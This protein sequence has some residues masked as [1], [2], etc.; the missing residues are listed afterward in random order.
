MKNSSMRLGLFTLC[1][2]VYVNMS[3]ASTHNK[4]GVFIK[5]I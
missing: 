1:L 4:V 3:F 2:R 5:A